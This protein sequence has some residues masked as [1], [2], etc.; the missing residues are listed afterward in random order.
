MKDDA[1]VRSGFY[2]SL[3]VG[4]RPALLII[5]FQRGFTEQGLTP[6]ASP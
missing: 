4:Q 1:N 2:G 3:Q 5:D 6:L